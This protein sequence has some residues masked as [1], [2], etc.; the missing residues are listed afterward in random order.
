MLSENAISTIFI[1][2]NI[3]T[4]I[5]FVF[6]FCKVLNDRNSFL[7]GLSAAIPALI[8]HLY[9]SIDYYINSPTGPDAFAFGAQWIMGGWVGP[10]FALFSFMLRSFVFKGRSKVVS[11][12]IGFVPCLTFYVAIFFNTWI[13]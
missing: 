13:A 10:T 7:T 3:S 9:L 8:F 2:L 11:I 4:P 5:V 6:L 1:L 12:L